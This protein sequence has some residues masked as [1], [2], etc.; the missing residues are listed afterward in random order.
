MSFIRIKA[1]EELPVPEETAVDRLSVHIDRYRSGLHHVIVCIKVIVTS[2]DLPETGS[3]GSVLQII[4]IAVQFIEAGRRGAVL[5]G[6]IVLFSVNNLFSGQGNTVFIK[7][8]GLAVAGIKSCFDGAVLV[9]IHIPSVTHLDQACLPHAGLGI[10]I[11]LFPVC[12][13]Q[14]AGHSAALLEIVI[15]LAVHG[16]DALFRRIGG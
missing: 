11:I 5:F 3:H 4:G 9:E 7:V 15:F 6:E 10:I 1:C 12:P 8:Q 13:A 2:V 16:L 14:T